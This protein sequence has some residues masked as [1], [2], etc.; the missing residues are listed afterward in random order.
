[1]IRPLIVTA[2]WLILSLSGCA[3]QKT[4]APRK[5]PPCETLVDVAESPPSRYQVKYQN[6]GIE[7][8]PNFAA[9]DRDSQYVVAPAR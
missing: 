6:Q 3:G 5:V 9:I 8:I 1:M 7:V 2:I 4:Q